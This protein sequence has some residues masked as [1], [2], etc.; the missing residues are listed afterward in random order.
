MYFFTVWNLRTILKWIIISSIG[1]VIA[2]FV[3]M[4]LYQFFP[5][6]FNDQEAVLMKGNQDKSDIALTFNISWG[7]KQVHE[8]LTVLKKHDVR[9]TFFVG[10][11]WAERH[12]HIIEKMTEDTH[13]IAMLGYRY[14]NYLQQE[15]AQIR[16]DLMYA[17]E[18]FRKLGNHDIKYFRPPTGLF[19]EEMVQTAKT[20]GLDVIYWSVNPRDWENKGIE[21]LAD[22]LIKQTSGGDIILLHASDDAKE[23]AKALEVVIPQL[24]EKELSFVTISELITEVDME[25]KLVE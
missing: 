23:T 15:A 13:E 1:I 7:D 25:E 14:K 9:A 6:L 17:K 3:I 20:L 10:G 4:R 11:E 12:P 24:K 22:E 8:V 19:N 5:F 16:K 2:F 21:V 18:V